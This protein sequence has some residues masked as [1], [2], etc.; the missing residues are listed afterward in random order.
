MDDGMKENLWFL[1]SRR[2]SFLT[3]L[4]RFNSFYQT[5]AERTFPDSNL[6]VGFVFI[7]IQVEIRNLVQV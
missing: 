7:A 6:Y 1:D 5:K 2:E 4:S 3:A